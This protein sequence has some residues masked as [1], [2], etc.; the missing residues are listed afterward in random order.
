MS[1]KG[2]QKMNTWGIVIGKIIRRQKELQMEIKWMQFILVLSLILALA[3]CSQSIAPSPESA[4]PAQQEG[5]ADEQESDNTDVEDTEIEDTNEGDAEDPET[6]EM[7]GT[8]SAIDA[9]Q[10][11]KRNCAGC[12]GDKRQGGSGPPLLPNRLTRSTSEYV[13]FI[14]QGSSGSGISSPMPS[15]GKRLTADEINALV[16]WILTPVD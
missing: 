15:F 5:P 16:E 2:A 14:K 3:A 10:L 12:H 8:P 13:E 9:A 7:D 11:Y 6:E 1:V 4:A